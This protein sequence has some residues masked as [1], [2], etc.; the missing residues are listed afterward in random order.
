MP[1]SLP[2]TAAWLVCQGLT[3]AGG[4]K[5]SRVKWVTVGREGTALEVIQQGRALHSE[6]ASSSWPCRPCLFRTACCAVTRIAKAQRGCHLPLLQS[7]RHLSPVP[8][9]PICA[10]LGAPGSPGHTRQQKHKP[11]S[12][13]QGLSLNLR[14]QHLPL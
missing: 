13:Q 12:S 7:S 3:A 5:Q 2:G 14:S 9:T 8:P 1:G 4:F 11:P 10:F 6:V